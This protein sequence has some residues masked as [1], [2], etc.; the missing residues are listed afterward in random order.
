LF[1][2][3]FHNRTRVAFTIL[4]F[5]SFS[6][7]SPPD[8]PSLPDLPFS[9]APGFYPRQASTVL[10][11]F[12]TTLARLFTISRLLSFFHALFHFLAEPFL[13][14]MMSGNCMP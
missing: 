10:A 6:F 9:P 1:F 13:L 7:P 14:L 5:F 11:L 2:V 8:L 12:I 4:A 3:D